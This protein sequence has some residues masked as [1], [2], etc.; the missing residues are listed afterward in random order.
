M[1]RR[2]TERESWK[3]RFEEC[4]DRER[5]AKDKFEIEKRESLPLAVEVI[6]TYHARY[7]SAEPSLS[8]GKWA[9]LHEIENHWQVNNIARKVEA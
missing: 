6:K 9:V 4:L 8:L 7:H 5:K 2:E 3:T 1:S